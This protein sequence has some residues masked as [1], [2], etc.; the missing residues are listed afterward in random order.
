LATAGSTAN[1]PPPA[2]P[3][4][5][6]AGAGRGQNA[7]AGQAPAGRGAGGGGGGGRGGQ[8]IAPHT[9]LVNARF[10]A[11]AQHDFATR[12]KWSVTPAYKGAN[13]EPVVKVDGPLARTARAGETVQLRGTAS[14]PDGDKVSVR[15]WHYQDPGTY[16]SAIV[17]P[18]ET[19]LDTTL[20]I[21]SDV[22][23]GQTIH[24]ILEATDG[25]TP[26]LTRYQRV[27]VTIK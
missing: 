10:F 4:E 14:D 2:P 22:Q 3:A 26:S 21:P 13:H 19:S 23:P 11:A 17:I 18:N 6:A 9:A 25:G 7:A 1:A 16:P 15:W 24:V 5:Q 8:P 12:M 27:V 20:T